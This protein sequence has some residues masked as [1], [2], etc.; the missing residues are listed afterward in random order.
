MFLTRRRMTWECFPPADLPQQEADE[1]T[2]MNVQS[3]NKGLDDLLYYIVPAPWYRKAWQLLFRPQSV[4][5]ADW[6]EQIDDLPAVRPWFQD[7]QQEDNGDVQKQKANV[8]REI[9]T[10]WKQTATTAGK[11]FEKKHEQDYYFVGQNTWQLLEN[12]FGKNASADAVSC[13]VVSFPSHDSRLAVNLPNGKRIPIPGSGRFAYEESL[14]KGGDADEAMDAVRDLQESELAVTSNGGSCVVLKQAPANTV[15][16]EDEPMTTDE[17]TQEGPIYMLPPSTTAQS[18]GEDPPGGLLA[19]PS[20]REYGSGLANLGNTCFMSATIQC[21]GHTH[22]VLKY[23]L[24]GSFVE[25]LNR[26][27]PLGTGGELAIEFAKLLREIWVQN[28]TVSSRPYSYVSNNVVYPR[29]FK[30]T[31]GK[32]AEQFSGYD[33]HDTQEFATYLLDALHED[34]NRITKK[35]YIEKPE[36]GED[37]SDEQAADKAWE[38]HLKRENSRIMES[39]MG[40]VKSRVQCCEEGCGR[41][42]TTFDPFLYLSVPIPGGSDRQIKVVYVPLDPDQRPKK[43]TIMVQKTGA[44]S[45]LLEKCRERVVGL[46]TDPDDLAL[47]DMVAVDVWNNEIY[48]W[49]ENK[50][51]VERI[52]DSDETFIYQLRPLNEVRRL[53]TT[54]PITTES[55]DDLEET[56]LLSAGRK[57]QLDLATLTVLNQRDGW[58][59]RFE[60]YSQ[61]YMAFVA[62]FNPSKGTTEGRM[63]FLNNLRLF[64]KK[65]QEILEKYEEKEAPVDEESAARR[66][67]FA[68]IPSKDPIP[69]LIE[70]T[71][72]SHLFENVASVYDVAVLEFCAG[73]MREEILNI[74]QQK[75]NQNFPDGV[76]VQVRSR[77]YGSY[78]SSRDQGLAGPLVLRI[79]SNM[80]VYELRE[81]LAYRMRRSLRSGRDASSSS[82]AGEGTSEMSTDQA[83]AVLSP[84]APRPTENGFDS[85]FG[86][87]GLMVMRQVPMSYER[88]KPNNYGYRGSAFSQLGALV[89]PGGMGEK[90]SSPL[91]DKSEEDE[92]EE[93]A[94]IVGDQGTVLL[95]WPLELADEHFDTNEYNSTEEAADDG[96]AID[97]HKPKKTTSVLD[98]IDR[99]C[100]TEQLEETEMWYC[101]KCQKHVQAWKQF[102]LYRAPPILIIH[103]K[104]FQY[105]AITHRRDKLGQFIDFPLEGLDLTEHV[106]HYKEEEKPI[107][108][109]YGVSNHYGGLGGGHYTAHALHDNGVWCYYDDTRITTDVDPKEA[110]TN[111]AYV[112]YYRRRDVPKD[113]EFSISTETP[114]IRRAPAIILENSDKAIGN[115]DLSGSNAAI[116]G[117]DDNMDIDNV[118]AASRSTSPMGSAGSDGDDLHAPNMISEFPMPDDHDQLPRQ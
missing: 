11:T 117:D 49:H 30:M 4:I 74:I 6:R 69:E 96:A 60:D 15:E 94:H 17:N 86:P 37:E 42:S 118:D 108:D 72:K 33:Q 27:N 103:L 50:N 24:S 84:P 43:L 35:P 63:K 56:E 71:E 46:G 65:C 61:N 41:V 2:V 97:G 105:S 38:L 113:S 90:R 106:M 81:E 112:L 101:N 23:F 21:L 109:C 75:K 5:C 104:R 22:Q 100:Q 51:D 39:F 92:K 67:S 28:S 12:K 9:H 62:L 83:A 110:V 44:V 10:A 76:L 29:N 40:Q 59:K 95:E 3:S 14:T 115:A 89:K 93:V 87:P 88:N 32:F 64:L 102:H 36:Q 47:E 70:L 68:T 54:P 66:Q 85:A 107:Y 52:R 80:T 34:T 13:H 8:S 78:A 19:K 111:A 99:Y 91:V 77:C 57:H 53:S 116:I 16:D 31:V 25:D 58:S 79:P 98:C 18:T 73:K 114:E 45:D 26:D 48:S 82:L 55:E 7:E 1:L 20:L